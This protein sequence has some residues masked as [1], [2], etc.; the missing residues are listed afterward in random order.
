MLVDV[1]I[2]INKL[3]FTNDM[4]W[5]A[6]AMRAGRDEECGRSGGAAG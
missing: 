3:S 4:K 2:F 6:G 5:A 1:T